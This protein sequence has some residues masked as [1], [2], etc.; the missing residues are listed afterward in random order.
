MLENL[1]ALLM[2]LLMIAFGVF[3]GVSAF[4]LI[5]NHIK[6]WR[7]SINSKTWLNTD[8]QVVDATLKHV[9]IRA[10]WKPT[11]TYA[12]RVDGVD[13]KNQRLTFDYFERYPLSD[14]NELMERYAVDTTVKVFY[15][16]EQP[17]ESTLE[18]A[19]Q[20]LTGGLIVMPLLL[21][22]PT[23]MCICAG[24]FGLM[25]IWNK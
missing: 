21:L 18:R 4:N 13:Y 7:L 15:D 1:M 8:G 11:I 16:P 14:A 5:Y 23:A 12:Y 24:L 25:D 9:G 22:F 10:G 17:Q 20:G 3:C 6:I 2:G 19:H